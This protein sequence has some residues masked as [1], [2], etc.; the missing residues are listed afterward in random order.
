MTCQTFALKAKS[1]LLALAILPAMAYAQSDD[2]K[3]KLPAISADMYKAGNENYILV[4]ALHDGLIKMNKHYDFRYESK[5]ITFNG[6]EVPAELRK[7]YEIKLERLLAT[8]GK[9]ENI[10]MYYR[11]GG[12]KE[13]DLI[14]EDSRFR[15]KIGTLKQHDEI[16]KQSEEIQKQHE[17]IRKQHEEIAKQHEVIVKQHAEIAK[18]HEAI[19]KRQ[20]TY[21]N[22]IIDAMYADKLINDKENLKIKW[23]Y[24]G[25]IVNGKKLKGEMADKYETMFEKETGMK[26]K[27]WDDGVS[28][29]RTP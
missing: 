6:K 14:N 8:N 24:R 15:N 3:D 5:H 2:L 16:V 12:I 29:T 28:I 1:L 13:K 20:T 22:K 21:T 10:M 7:S 19:S 17:E 9:G 11:G 4:D 26:I 18:E 23:N 27:Q 25:V